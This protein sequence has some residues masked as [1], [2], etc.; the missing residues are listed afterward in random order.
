MF[1]AGRLVLFL[2]L[3]SVLLALVPGAAIVNVIVV[4]L[5][6]HDPRQVLLSHG[7]GGA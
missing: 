5:F 4:V 6:Y 1:C 2:S 7:M 3:P